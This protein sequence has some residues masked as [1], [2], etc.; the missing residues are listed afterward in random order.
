MTSSESEPVSKWAELLYKEFEYRHGL[1]WKSLYL[2]GGAVIA[3]L[4]AP[5]LKSELRPLGEAVYFFPM[6]GLVLSFAGAWHLAA[7]AERIAAV[8]KRYN[9]LRGSFKPGWPYEGTRNFYEHAVTE[10][11]RTVITLLFL[12]GFTSL[13]VVSTLFIHI[14]RTQTQSLALFWIAVAILIAAALY[15]A[16]WF[17]VRRR[18]HNC[19]TS[20]PT[21][22]QPALQRT[23]RKRAAAELGR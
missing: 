6:V 21:A 13:A 2:W 16:L 14:V 3:V 5:F 7:E 8:L 12:V 20:R 1:Y 9:E 11:V 15:I 4:L 23:A 22:A 18:R 17:E 10:P 19:S